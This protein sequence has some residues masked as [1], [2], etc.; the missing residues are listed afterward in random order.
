MPET[1]AGSAKSEDAPKAEQTTQAEPPPAGAEGPLGTAGAHTVTSLPPMEG[2]AQADPAAQVGAPLADQAPPSHPPLPHPRGGPPDPTAPKVDPFLARQLEEFPL[3]ET[4]KSEAAGALVAAR[5]FS[6]EKDPYLADARAVPAAV[7]IDMALQ[8]ASRLTQGSA[9][10]ISDVRFPAPLQVGEEPVSATATAETAE[11][12]SVAVRIATEPFGVHAA[13]RVRPGAVEAPEE[14]F[15]APQPP[16][17]GSFSGAAAAFYPAAGLGPRLQ[18][19]EG[20]LAPGE[21]TVL[22]RVAPPAQEEAGGLATYQ[23]LIEAAFQAC[24]WSRSPE[25]GPRAPAALELLQAFPDAPPR[26]PLWVRVT[27]RGPVCDAWVFNADGDA[28]LEVRGVTS[29]R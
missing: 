29:A 23:R 20:L 8:A 12:G 1:A 14:S 19:L 3:L 26:A 17:D 11:D 4:I 6:R 28:V 24:A 27:R 10:R 15:A 22:A 21:G 25:G 2:P 7:W 9:D 5:A 16:A 13:A 18:V